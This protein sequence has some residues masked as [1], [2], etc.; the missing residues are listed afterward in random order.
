[1]A[2]R[3]IVGLVCGLPNGAF[4]HGSGSYCVSSCCQVALMNHSAW[5]AIKKQK[6]VMCDGFCVSIELNC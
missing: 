2:Y 1:M 5:S 6:S 3:G 4:P